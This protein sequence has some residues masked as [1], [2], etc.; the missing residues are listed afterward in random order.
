MA[1]QDTGVNEAGAVASGGTKS[2]VG[3]AD[4]LATMRTRLT[5]AISAY[6]D[7]REDELDD[8]RFRAASPDNQWQWPA[9]VLATRGSIQGQTINARPCLTINKLPQHVL[10]VTNDQRQNRPSGKVIPADDKADVEVAEIFNGIVRHI[11]YISDADVAYD[12]ACDNQVT[13]GEGYF[14]ILTEYCDENSFDQDLRIGRIRDSFSVYMDP[15]I[16]D[17]CGSD[18]EW[19][20]INQE[21]TKEEY[22]RQFPNAATLSSLQYGVGDGQLNAWVNQDTV[23]IAEYFHIEHK[24]KTL[25]QYHGG[26]TAMKGSVEAKQAEMMGLVAI[27]SR[28]V[29]VKTVKWCKTNGFEVLESRDWAGKYIPVIRVI[30]NEFEIDG[31][32][33]V[34]GLV[35]NAKDAQRMYNYWVSQEAEMLALAP[36]APFIGYGGQFE[37][38]EQQWK[39]ANINNWPYLEVNP[40]VTDGQGNVLPLPARAQPPMASSGLLQAKAGAS[41]DIKSSTGQYDSSLGATSNERSGRAIL[42]REKQSDTGTYHYVDN[43]ARAIRYA[44]RQLVDMIP[45]IYDTQRIARI[46]GVDG[47]TDQAMIDPTQP[48]PVKKIQDERGIVIK[49]I[50]NPGV[51][52]YDVAVTTGPS[53]MTKRQE[54]LDAMS[55]LLQGNPQLWAVA[56]DLFIKNMDWPGAQEMSQ[57]FAKTIDPKLLSNEDDPALQA[58]H[59]QMQAMGKEMEQMHAMLKNV[60]QSMEAQDLKIKQFD[61]EVK[62]YD[63]ETKRISAVQAGMSPEQIQDIVLGT[64]HGMITSGD[65][66]SEM[67]GRD[68]DMPGMPEMPQE[69]MEPPPMGVPQ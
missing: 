20:F 46:I 61:S 7:S 3:N 57:R 5:M 58:A 27:K 53:Y 62:A 52:K 11:E 33:Y 65:L 47:E 51:G 9:D 69:G 42:A 56:G 25:N 12:T 30:G 10:Q 22:E 23:R 45:K 63:A 14:R 8:L 13:F 16:Q 24:T 31:R 32:M 48:M 19:C 34:S 21:L 60:G 43:L 54:S 36:K 28:E 39:T 40:D 55:Q 59:Q 50:Y 4:M 44:T 67:P 68:S 38:Y 1:Y 6:S 18:A 49:K 66:I 2:D 26:I 35:R 37:G 64:V 29:D 15:T 41:D 17:P